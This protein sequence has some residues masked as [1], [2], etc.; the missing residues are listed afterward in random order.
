MNTQASFSFSKLGFLSLSFLSS[1]VELGP[2]ILF[3]GSGAGVIGT[4]LVGMCYQIGNLIAGFFQLPLRWI[5]ALSAISV[6]LAV[7]AVAHPN[8]LYG[9]VLL[10][11]ISI[12]EMRRIFSERSQGTAKASTLLKRTIRIVGFA[13]AGFT[14]LPLYTGITALALVMS[15]TLIWK[16]KSYSY[17]LAP[18]ADLKFS[19][20]AAIMVIH[21]TH[22]FT[23]AY[24]LPLLFAGIFGLN[25]FLIGPAFIVGWISYA[26]VETIVSQKN[27]VKVFI[28]GHLIVTASLVILALHYQDIFTVLVAWFVSGLGGGTVFCLT[29][30]NRVA[31]TV[32]VA[33]EPWEDIGHVVGVIV[34]LVVYILSMSLQL[35]FLTAASAALLAAISI[36]VYLGRPL[37]L[38]RGHPQS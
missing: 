30:L 5:G 3:A 34:A 27:L 17:R 32:R 19:P 8:L 2:I 22:Y 26:S 23:Y 31:G 25:E 38:F 4:L 37:T 13:T 29:R 1:I 7:A 10:T 18:K 28:I 16:T 12:Q 33:M 15:L 9:S 24:L 14:T 21:Q 35:I 11:S 20:L 36:F 6:A